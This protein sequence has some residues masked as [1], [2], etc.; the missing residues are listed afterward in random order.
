MQEIKTFTS[1]SLALKVQI[2]E[3]NE[4]IIL[5]LL[6]RS[7]ERE[8]SKFLNPILIEADLLRNGRTVVLDF[9]NLEYMNSST[10]TPL[11]QYIEKSR[12]GNKKVTLQYNKSLKWQE[13]SF[14]ALTV[15]QVENLIQINGV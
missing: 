13:L 5:K 12:R 2:F 11:I 1:P 9:G 6:G 7:V 3:D 14:S 10:I 8:P 15:F 4:A